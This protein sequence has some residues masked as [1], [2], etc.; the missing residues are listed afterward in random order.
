MA[1]LGSRFSVDISRYQE[2]FTDK[3]KV[4]TRKTKV[5]QFIKFHRTI[6]RNRPAG[7]MARLELILI[8][9]NN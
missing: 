2:L 6:L 8:D 3:K 7:F 1:C 5:V 4:K 9:I